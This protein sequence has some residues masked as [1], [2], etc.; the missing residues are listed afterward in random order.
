MALTTS[1][2]NGAITSS[3]QSL[4]ITSA[5]DVTAGDYMLIDQ[6]VV[7]VGKSYTSGTTIPL[8]GRGLNGTVAAAHATG[9]NIVHGAGS[10]FA[11]AGPQVALPYPVAGRARTLTSYSA[12]GAIALPTAG[13]D[14]VAVLNGTSTLAMTLANP[15][16]DMDGSILFVLGNGKSASTVT[17]S[18][19]YGLAG[20]GYTV[21]TFQNAG[22]VGFTLMAAN[23]AWVIIGAPPI[24]GT[25]TEVSIA[26]S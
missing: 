9:A 23:A 19:G 18:D 11:N 4:V 13:T 2:L 22:V 16:K 1:T 24:T 15:T 10:D 6:E 25:S 26:I 14:A 3:A 21:L 20:S 8:S 5:T 12:S 7:R 17:V